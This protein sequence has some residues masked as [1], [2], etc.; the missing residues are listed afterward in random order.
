M[1]IIND[2]SLEYAKETLLE[3]YDEEEIIESML[4][5]FLYEDNGDMFD[6]EVSNLSYAKKLLEKLS[7]LQTWGFGTAEEPATNC[8][9]QEKSVIV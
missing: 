6:C 3:C 4:H 8:W 7:Q 2:E 1:D 5:E 9:I